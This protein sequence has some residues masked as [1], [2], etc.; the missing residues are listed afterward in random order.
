M[1]Q[2]GLHIPV[3]FL[4]CI[5]VLQSISDRLRL[6]ITMR[7]ALVLFLSYKVCLAITSAA[8]NRKTVVT[9]NMQA[10]YLT[11]HQTAVA[12]PLNHCCPDP[13]LP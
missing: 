13:A 5:H 11:Y 10:K 2:D 4:L 9:R 6:C 8:K 7:N 3:P 12:R 1:Q